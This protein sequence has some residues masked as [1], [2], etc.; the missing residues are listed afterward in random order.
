MHTNATVVPKK[1]GPKTGIDAAT[2]ACT[3][4]TTVRLQLQEMNQRV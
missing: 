1:S 4:D 3:D 2:V